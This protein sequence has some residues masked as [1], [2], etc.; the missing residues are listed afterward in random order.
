ME[1]LLTSNDPDIQATIQA[2]LGKLNPVTIPTT[3]Q[4]GLASYGVQAP[5]G[6][7]YANGDLKEIPKEQISGSNEDIFLGSELPPVLQDIIYSVMGVNGRA[8]LESEAAYQRADSGKE[9]DAIVGSLGL[10]AK[11]EANRASFG[12]VT[13][14]LES[15]SNSTTLK[16]Y[17]KL[18]T[19]NTMIEVFS[20]ATTGRT[21]TNIRDVT[22]PQF[23]NAAGQLQMISQSS[24][25]KDLSLAQKFFKARIEDIDNNPEKTPKMIE[26][27]NK[28]QK[29]R[30]NIIRLLSDQYN[31]VEKQLGVELEDLDPY[32]S[33]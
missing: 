24:T 15:A 33:R 6:G 16:H 9:I 22:N 5:F 12:F 26:Q 31:V 7:R 27:R 23:I 11:Q 14:P 10:S 2:G 3:A 21:H 4:A 18:E 28:M 8:I 20:N 30:L 32:K 1:S 29:T 25:V 17:K 13:K 19:I